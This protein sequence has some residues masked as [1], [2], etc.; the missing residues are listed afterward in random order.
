MTVITVQYYEKKKYERKK[1]GADERS[2][3]GA[4]RENF[5]FKFTNYNT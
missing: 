2:D 5:S 3:K 4:I 1:R